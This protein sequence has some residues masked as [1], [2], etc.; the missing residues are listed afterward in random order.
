MTLQ[1][2]APFEALERSRAE[3]LGMVSHELRTPLAAIKGSAATA[4]EDERDPD[5]DELRQFLR[6]IEEQ[7]GRMSGLI[8]D[9]LDAGRLG[10]GLLPVDPAPEDVA[11]LVE[12][13]RTA[14]AGRGGRHSLVID[15]PADLPPVLADGRRIV[16]VL[17]NLLANAARHSPETAPIRIVAARDGAQV[18][19]SVT[20]TGEGVP[21]ERL[22]HLFRRHAGGDAREGGSSGLGLVICKG[23]VEAHG[24]RIRAESDGAGRGTRITF[25]LPAAEEEASALAAPASPV[26]SSAG[27]RRPSWWWTTTR[28]R[29]ARWPT[30]SARQATPRRRRA[31]RGRWRT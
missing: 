14:F 17:D 22:P 20:D 13:A 18:E 30:P 28:T 5:R 1:D 8:G 25:T 3:F 16:Q 21:A 7:A 10:A 6:I 29:G 12:R 27:D 24:G 2:L 19:V 11:G 15:L 26:G 31:S 4:L 9:L 23:L